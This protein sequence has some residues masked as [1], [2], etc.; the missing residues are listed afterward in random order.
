[1]SLH[2][3]HKPKV[4]RPNPPLSEVVVSGPLFAEPAHRP[5]KTE[6]VS[7]TDSEPF[8]L[9][10]TTTDNPN[11][12]MT[13]LAAA[14]QADDERAFWQAV[15][16]IDWS[17]RSADDFGQAV[18]LALQI[19][20]HLVA[21]QLAVDGA[22]RYPDS[23]SLQKYARVLAPPNITRRTPAQPGVKADIDWFRAHSAEYRGQW[24]AVK[25][26][27]LLAAAPSLHDLQSQVPDLR[28][29]TITR[30]MW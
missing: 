1:M 30:V 7:G 29:A 18:Q 5:G 6:R 11:Y 21:R 13:Q 27:E 10:V 22:A 24:V 15:Q 28:T 16:A 20:A 4:R 17:V 9:D 25:N 3:P 12:A 2:V 19:G 26:G 14:A 8:N 23:A